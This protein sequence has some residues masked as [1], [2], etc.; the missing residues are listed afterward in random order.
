MA[1]DRFFTTL[2]QV[3]TDSDYVGIF[4]TT[5]SSISLSSDLGSLS[6]EGAEIVKW[7]RYKFGEPVITLEIDNLQIF[8]MFEEANIEYSSI[9]NTFNARNWMSSLLGLNRN[10]TEQDL[11]QKLPHPTMQQLKRLS[12][13]FA[14]EAGIG[15]N[16]NLRK[17]YIT[18]N[19]SDTDYD[20]YNDFIDDATGLPV[21]GYLESVSS[22]TLNVRKVW[23]SE[24]STIYRYFDPYSSVN[25]LS[26]E[27]QYESLNT[28]T[29]FYVQ[30]IWADI[31]RG[32][33][34]ETSDHVRRS[35]H[36]YQING[37][38][39][40]LLPKPL[41]PFK[42]WIEYD[43]FQD[44]FNADNGLSTI[45]DPSVTGITDLSNVPLRDIT[46][47]S[48]NATGKRWVRQYTY[49]LT[50]ELV[51]RIRRKYGEIPIPN[52]S[53][54]L[55][56]DQLIGEGNELKLQLKEELKEEL[57]KTSNIE[58]LREEAE[59]ADLIQQQ[60]QHVPMPIFLLG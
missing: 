11:T 30:P 53:I 57:D 23:H 49:A 17:A 46:Y 12:E 54:T 8:A 31:L 36:T 21:S 15:G 50:L 3:A 32:S 20:L 38:R 7:V 4:G 34:L 9:I 16:V 41:K 55:D 44:P 33:T 60:W 59:M 43:S 14:T 42:L 39:I 48:L 40:R 29:I 2:T 45:G 52:G 51:G 24:P 18:L 47:S 58:R 13:P 56:G 6:S 35:T 10:Y 37:T 26:Q 27:F 22:A 19:T 1:F 28:E 25:L 5:A